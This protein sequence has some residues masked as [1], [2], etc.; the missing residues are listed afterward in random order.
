MK[1]QYFKAFVVSVLAMAGW[2]PMNPQPAHGGVLGVAAGV[3]A[4]RN[5]G[6]PQFGGPWI[7]PDVRFRPLGLLD[8]ERSYDD[9]LPAPNASS[10]VIVK[11]PDANA[12]VWVQGKL[13][14]MTGRERVFTSPP[15]ESGF[16]YSYEVRAR[17]REGND[18]I[19][20]TRTVSVRPAERVHVDFT[21]P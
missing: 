6:A 14:T 21:R 19:D 10:Q 13:T 7:A 9:E 1:C 16:A 17:W 12:Q 15:L 5:F 8:A 20:R 3:W 11:V 4:W 18:N 2:L